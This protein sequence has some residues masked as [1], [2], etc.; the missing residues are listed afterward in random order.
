MK[1][2]IA[3]IIG[4]LAIVFS[5]WGLWLVLSGWEPSEDEEPVAC[6]MDAKIC[7][8]GSY[9]GR[10]SPGCE[11]AACPKEESIN[12]CIKTGCSGQICSNKDVITTCEFL[13]EYA[14]YQNARCERQ[15]N[16]SCGWTMTQ[17]LKDCLNRETELR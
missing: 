9:V 11:F 4:L 7:S 2:S 10:V 5:F 13:P 16:G 14:C 1:K 12:Y 15:S 6:T 8:D 3:I 17:E